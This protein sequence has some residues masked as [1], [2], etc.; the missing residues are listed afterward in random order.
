M[1]NLKSKTNE[2]AKQNRSRITDTEN[3]QVAARREECG[4]MDEIGEGN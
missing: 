4:Q 3:K 1:Q 2:Q